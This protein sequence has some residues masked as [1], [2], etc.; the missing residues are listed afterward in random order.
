MQVKPKYN[1]RI[2]YYDLSKNGLEALVHFMHTISLPQIHSAFSNQF[3]EIT[4][5][6]SEK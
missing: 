5:G 4:I 2:C 1:S 3:T 6:F